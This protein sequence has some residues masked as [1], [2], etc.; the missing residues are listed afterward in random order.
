MGRGRNRYSFRVCCFAA[1]EH[2]N[3]I[4]LQVCG[5]VTSRLR[6]ELDGI[7]S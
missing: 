1:I 6:R 4:G 7:G 2:G 3:R 5:R